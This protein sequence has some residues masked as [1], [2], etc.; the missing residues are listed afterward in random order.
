MAQMWFVFGACLVPVRPGRARG[1]SQR[2]DMACD[3][4]VSVK[5][6]QGVLIGIIILAIVVIL[7]LAAF[8]PVMRRKEDVAIKTVKDRL[9]PDAIKVIEPRTTA[10]GTD[11]EEAGGLRGMSCLAVNDEELMAVTWTGLREWHI[12]RS[13]I[14]GVDSAADDPTS[15]QKATVTVAYTTPEGE[16]TAMFRLREPVAWLT[17]LGYDWGPDGPPSDGADAAEDE[18]E[19]GAAAA[20]D[21]D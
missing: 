1:G 5:C 17:E 9:G 3:Q 8:N 4:A 20:P 19:S 21:E 18:S 16:A 11:P 7:V 10:M 12:P 6:M 15:V 14:T 2:P 13:S